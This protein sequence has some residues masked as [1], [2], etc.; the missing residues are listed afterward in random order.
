MKKSIL[1]LLAAFAVVNMGATAAQADDVD[2]R[3]RVHETTA[4]DGFGLSVWVSTPSVSDGRVLGLAGVGH[5]K[6][7]RLAELMVGVDAGPGAIVGVADVRLGDSVNLGKLKLVGWANLRWSNFND[8]DNSNLYGLFMLSAPICDHFA[9][10]VESEDVITAGGAGNGASDFSFG[11]HAVVG[12]SV[13]DLQLAYQKHSD[14]SNQ[15]WL[16]ASV[17][18]GK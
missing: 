9:V 13:V 8:P 7:G 5:A 4:V 18:F 14:T 6:D 16:R 12:L 15:I 17:D 2:A 3:V 11:P 1:M 10:G